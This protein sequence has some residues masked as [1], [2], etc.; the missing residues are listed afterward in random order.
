MVKKF[1]LFGLLLL[2]IGVVSANEVQ[3][4]VNTPTLLKAYC[5]GEGATADI[6]I[7]SG[8]NMNPDNL[9]LARISML[10]VSPSDFIDRE[11]F[12][13]TGVFTAFME[14]SY[15]GGFVTTQTTTITVTDY[16]DLVQEADK[17]GYDLMANLYYN[18]YFKEDP[19]KDKTI[20]FD[21]GS[22]VITF[23]PKDLNIINEADTKKQVIKHP[24]G[25]ARVVSSNNVVSYPN[26]YGA[27]LTL[28]YQINTRYVK[29]DLVI[30]SASALPIAHSDLGVNPFLE[31][32]FKMTST[33]KHFIVDGVEW[34][35]DEQHSITTSNRVL[36]NDAS[37]NTIYVL[38][39]PVAFDSAGAEVVGKYTLRKD[40]DKVELSVK[41]PY[42][43]LKNSS[44]VFPIF[45]DPTIDTPDGTSTFESSVPRIVISDLSIPADVPYTITEQIL[46][47]NQII[48]DAECET[49]IYDLDLDILDVDFRSFYN[50]GWGNMIFVWGLP[51]TVA[52]PT[53]GNHQLRQYCWQGD[54]LRLNKIYSNTSITVY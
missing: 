44:R 7:Y 28:D 38:E 9:W 20:R 27:G 30:G 23:Q 40:A 37:G 49:D 36:I 33:T 47:D 53:V 54:T 50:D 31:L 1:V 17:N 26:I 42:L 3:V 29:E 13:D 11:T 24:Q 52:N 48:Y 45:V 12:G 10:Q 6:Q 2:A 16:A 41:M 43:W 14:C 25:S 15:G 8:T 39:V 51:N 34:D 35:M 21:L 46:I 32:N 18:V 22:D 19:S 5:S 4:D